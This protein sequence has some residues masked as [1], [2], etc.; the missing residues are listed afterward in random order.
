MKSCLIALVFLLTFVWGCAT[1]DRSHP[2]L[3]DWSREPVVDLASYAC[4]QRRPGQNSNVV[5]VAAI[6]GGGHRSGNF[7]A[8]VFRALEA[9]P[10]GDTIFNLLREIDYFSTV[11]GGGFA[12]GAYL[13]TLHDHLAG[14]G[15]PAAYSFAEAL[16]GRS[17]RVRTNLKRSLEL[18]YHNRLA[19][20]LYSL[21]SIG[22]LDRGDYLEDRLD[23]KILGQESRAGGRSLTLGD[24]FVPVQDQAGRVP[25]L[26]YWFANATVYENG[27]IFPFA[28][29]ILAKYGISGYT[30]GLKPFTLTN[31]YALPL[32]VGMKASASFPGAVP[33][34][35]LK[36]SADRHNPYV[37]LFD[38][39]LADNL[40]I[41]TAVRL[42]EADPCPHKI[43]LVID[44]YKGTTEPFSK[45]AG[46]PKILQILPRST[47]ISLD[48]SH[49]R[50]D[51]L[52]ERLTAGIAPRR[53]VEVIYLDFES[54]PTET[55][56]ESAR[57]VGTTL[58]IDDET[59]AKLLC[60]GR[61]AVNQ[62]RD[63]LAGIVARLFNG[64]SN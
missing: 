59:Q 1:R 51:E 19:R 43:L 7:A 11:S 16:E 40:G 36:S 10:I 33:A 18:G 6:S 37:H 41:T 14:G 56:R 21:G 58:N 13:S 50:R 64:Q 46:S 28:P 47:G 44:S 15:A 8:G 32:A 23:E 57:E 55:D 38:G 54:L 27:A 53:P 5:V 20:G 24:V 4:V 52:V 12:A 48:S 26:P 45:T 22:N 63:K 49:S 30:H 2:Q 39:G 62:H 31:F 9:I 17:P 3:P 29:D 61:E 60:Y 42:L 34:T 25:K 35:T